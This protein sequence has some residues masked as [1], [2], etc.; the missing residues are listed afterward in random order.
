MPAPL[1][2]VLYVVAP[3]MLAVGLALLG[4]AELAVL[5]ITVPVLVVAVVTLLAVTPRDAEIVVQRQE[6]LG[7]DDLIFYGSSPTETPSAFL[8]QMHVAVANMGGRKGVLSRLDLEELQDERG[9]AVRP[10]ET[11]FPMAAQIYR[12]TMSYRIERG[13]MDR[14]VNNE[15]GGLP[16]TLEPD[17]VVTLRF[18]CRR[19]IDWSPRWTLEEIQR[20]VESLRRPIVRARIR[21]VY[22]RGTRVVTTHT[23]VPV[24]TVLQAEYVARIGLLTNELTIRP[25]VPVQ[26]IDLE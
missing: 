20:F 4:Y 17:D 14:V 6:E 24:K 2:A 10:L 23:T 5:V 19:G 8:L 16:L 1:R 13:L 3:V 9:R 21:I 11:P 25:D 18:R 7:Y 22:R 15:I 26:R 12:Q